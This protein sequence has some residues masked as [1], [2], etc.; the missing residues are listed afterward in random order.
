MILLG[1]EGERREK[2]M[3]IKF[4]MTKEV[5]S[6]P[7][8]AT[9]LDAAKFMTDM[10]VGSVVVVEDGNKPV[11]ILT[12]RD[13]MT[14]ATALEKDPRALR[15]RDIMISPVVTVSADKDIEDVTNLMNTHKVRRFP[16]VENGR[17]IGVIALDDILVFLGKE[18]QDI[19]TALKVELGK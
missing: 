12:D 9:V 1:A 18:M 16:V 5:T 17:L 13:I 4:L 7:R 10:N 6:L 2:A 3:S 14:K 15:V 19:A 11:G 8:D